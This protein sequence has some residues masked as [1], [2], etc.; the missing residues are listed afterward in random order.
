VATIRRII[1]ARGYPYH[2]LLNDLEGHPISVKWS[3][4]DIKHAPP[5]DNL[6]IV[7]DYIVAIKHIDDRVFPSTFCQLPKASNILKWKC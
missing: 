4:H 5:L 3:A 2:Y 7:A 6:K 1:T